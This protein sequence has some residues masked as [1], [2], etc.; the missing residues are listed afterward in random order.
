[1]GWGG[2]EGRDAGEAG[3]RRDAPALGRAHA[4]EARGTA[5]G[6]CPRENVPRS[7]RKKKNKGGVP[8]GFFASGE[9]GGTAR[10]WEKDSED[11]CAVGRRW[12]GESV[13]EAPR[14]PYRGYFL[15][16]PHAQAMSGHLGHDV[17]C[18]QVGEVCVGLWGRPKG[19]HI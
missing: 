5:E 1:M 3:E 17:V 9:P 16:P 6:R 18:L 12:A 7:T 14:N 4:K 11:T 8:P 15:T 10:S 13:R 2:G 19:E